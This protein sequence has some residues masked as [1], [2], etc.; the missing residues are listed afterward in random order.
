MK[1]LIEIIEEQLLENVE[2]RSSLIKQEKDT[3]IE[4]EIKKLEKKKELL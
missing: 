2:L 1:K 4:S 3:R